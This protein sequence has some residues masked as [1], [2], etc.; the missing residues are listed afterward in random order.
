MTPNCVTTH[1][2]TKPYFPVE[3]KHVFKPQ[4][5]PLVGVYFT[6]YS[7]MHQNC[8]ALTMIY[9]NHVLCL[10][11]TNKHKVGFIGDLLAPTYKAL[12]LSILETLPNYVELFVSS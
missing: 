8:L 7:N 11:Y 4:S 10:T 2:T 5:N 12:A 9:T 1:A 3:L 6:V